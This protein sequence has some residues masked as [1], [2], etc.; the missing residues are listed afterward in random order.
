VPAG[1]PSGGHRSK[2]PQGAACWQ[3]PGTIRCA[4]HSDQAARVNR[5]ADNTT[6]A[7]PAASSAEP[8]FP[9]LTPPQRYHFEVYGFV[10]VPQLLSVTETA[11][12]LAELRELRTSLVT[13]AGTAAADENPPSSGVR[14]YP[15]P[16]PGGAVLEQRG[17][18]GGDDGRQ[19]MDGLQ[20]LSQ[21][22]GYIT[23][24]AAHPVLVG[25]ASELLGGEARLMQEDAIINRRPEHGDVCGEFVPGWH[26]GA[27]VPFAAHTSRTSGLIHVNFVK[28]RTCSTLLQML[29]Y[30]ACLET[31]KLSHRVCLQ[32]LTNLTPLGPMDGG[33]M[34][35]SWR[36]PVRFHRG[37]HIYAV[38]VVYRHSCLELT[39][40]LVTSVICVR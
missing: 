13:K 33:T 10:I 5:F 24:Y 3:P 39:S 21:L 35:S 26:R 37:T 11:D 22:G 25:M 31:G 6:M 1:R 34:V 14:R 16:A 23:G 29:L 18:G 7:A 17:G 28:A 2:I 36:A 38:G 8:P 9:A 19:E 15:S 40:S 27:D 4:V 30:A 32:A 12:L 20:N